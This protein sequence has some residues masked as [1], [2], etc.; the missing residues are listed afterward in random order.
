M[1]RATKK[2]GYGRYI[3]YLYMLSLLPRS[4]TRRCREKKLFSQIF[5]AGS[6]CAIFP[7][8][9]IYPKPHGKIV[10]KSHHF[11]SPK[12]FILGEFIAQFFSTWLTF[13]H[14]LMTSFLS[15]SPPPSSPS[16]INL[17]STML[18]DRKLD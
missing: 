18:L 3:M 4:M 16:A 12:Q 8:G 15:Q 5:S 13:F 11:F 1:K 17:Y 14:A 9:K 7:H 10:S 6:H 2:Q